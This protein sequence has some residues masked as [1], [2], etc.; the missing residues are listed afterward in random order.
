MPSEHKLT[1]AQVAQLRALEGR[2]PDTEDIPE[3]PAAHWDRARRGMFRPRKAAIS[4]R[5]DMDVLAWLRARGPGYQTEINRILRE[6]MEAE[7]REG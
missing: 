3:A 6:R 1:D 7:S 2:E 4:L 5:L